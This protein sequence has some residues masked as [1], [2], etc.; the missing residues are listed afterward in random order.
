MTKNVAESENH[1]KL[2]L[3]A[4]N[5]LVSMGF[6]G[7]QIHEEYPVSVNSKRTLWVDVA[8]ISD[9]LTV[10]IECGQCD[11]SKITVL[12]MLFDKVIPL[13]Y[14][15]VHVDNTSTIRKLRYQ[16]K[17]LL[18]EVEELKNKIHDLRIEISN[19]DKGEA[20]FKEFLVL[21]YNLFMH[22]NIQTKDICY[23][24]SPNKNV[25]VD[26]MIKKLEQFKNNDPTIETRMM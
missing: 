17:E 3:V 4:R 11:I 7:S 10:A 15:D 1:K 25:I 5:M 20:L 21:T 24:G 8:G 22:S 23:Y 16:N 13:P 12:T 2:K 9:E 6:N 14:C 19:H 26:E 18:K